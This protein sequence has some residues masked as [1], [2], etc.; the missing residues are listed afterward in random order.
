MRS[1]KPDAF[2]ANIVHV[3]ENRCDGANSR[4]GRGFC[5]PRRGVK[6]LNEHLV[7]EVVEEEELR[8]RALESSAPDLPVNLGSARFQTHLD[9][10]YLRELERGSTSCCSQIISNL[11]WHSLDRRP[12]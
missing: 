5:P 3:G 12:Q 2:A 1:C 10:W 4:T 11:I 8:G 9:P 7:D 6:M